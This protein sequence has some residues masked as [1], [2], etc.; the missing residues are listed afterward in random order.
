MC[1][2]NVYFRKGAEE[3]LLMED[4]AWIEV[5]GSHVRLQDIMGKEKTLHARFSKANLVD[6]HILLEPV[7]AL[8]HQLEDLLDFAVRLHGHLGPYLVLGVRMGLLARERLGCKGHFDLKATVRTGRKT[9]LSCIADGV[10]AATGAT[11]GK[12]NLEVGEMEGELPGASFEHGGRRLEVTLKPGV[13]Q[14]AAQADHDHL[15]E[16]ARQVAAL[17]VDELF[18]VAE[19]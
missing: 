1:Q 17:P 15:E 2:S 8:P 18:E 4:V 11:P 9:P 10:M 14:L 6:H 5:Q 7:A 19:G 16:V 12:G 3:A 13:A